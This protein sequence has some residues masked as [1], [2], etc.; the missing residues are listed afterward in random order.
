MD[1]RI[2]PRAVNILRNK[3]MRILSIDGGGFLGLAVGT[4]RLT[5][6]APFTSALIYFVGRAR[7]Q[8]SRSD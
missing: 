4:L 8:L 2:T 1:L 3:R 7:E 5:S 6:E